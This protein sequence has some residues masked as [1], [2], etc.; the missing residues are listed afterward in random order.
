[1]LM[2]CPLCDDPIT[3]PALADAQRGS[4]FHPACVVTPLPQD[5]IVA[6]IAAAAAVLLPAIVVWAGGA[7]TLAPAARQRPTATACVGPAARGRPSSACPMSSLTPKD[8][9]PQ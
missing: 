6:L 9:R 5:A 1:M 3:G 8:T 7:H 2:L 4:A